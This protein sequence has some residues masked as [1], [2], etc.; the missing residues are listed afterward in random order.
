MAY[1]SIRGSVNPLELRRPQGLTPQQSEDANRQKQMQMREDEAANNSLIAQRDALTQSGILQRNQSVPRQ[2]TGTTM[3]IGGTP[4]QGSSGSAMSSL[5]SQ[6]SGGARQLPPNLQGR[7]MPLLELG[8]LDTNPG[9]TPPTVQRQG[10]SFTPDD[11][12]AYQSA[13]Y[14]RLKDRAGAAGQS[15]V[16][17]LSEQLAG[18]GISGR[19]GTFG[20][21]LAD[22]VSEAVQPLSDLNVA[23]LGE[24]YAASGRARQLSENAA[25]ESYQGGIAQRGQDIQS[26]QALQALRAALMQT[27][28]QGDLTQYMNPLRNLY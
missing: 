24:E 28:Y 5:A 11:A 26:Q 22:R 6:V 23:H 12:S 18:R 16:Q 27:K 9:S 25:S 15:A 21:G 8:Q 3:T 10:G 20:R 19:S 4:D 14:A 2:I 13:S 1:G 7:F 17:S